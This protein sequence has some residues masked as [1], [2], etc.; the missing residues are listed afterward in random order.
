MWFFPSLTRGCGTN[1]IASRLSLE[2]GQRGNPKRKY[3]LESIG[4]TNL[5]ILVA[6]NKTALLIP[7]DKHKLFICPSIEL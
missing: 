7:C 1:Q 6:D 5:D 2:H 3:A 4:N